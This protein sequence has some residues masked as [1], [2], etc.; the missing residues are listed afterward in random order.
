M[1]LD[2]G[3]GG[4]LSFDGRYRFGTPGGTFECPNS[5]SLK[6]L[7][8]LNKKVRPF[9]LSNNSIWSFPLCFIPWRFRHLEVLKAILALRSQHLEHLGSLSPSTIIG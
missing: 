4:N 7:P 1:P 3:P 8:T 6:T 5:V 9:F 2:S